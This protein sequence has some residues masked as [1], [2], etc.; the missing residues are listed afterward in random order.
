MDD[1][2]AAFVM[3]AV[4]FVASHGHRF[5]RLY[6]FDAATGAWSHREYRGVD[7]ALSLEAALAAGGCD[8]TALP[9]AERLRIYADCLAQARALA[10][11][12]GEPAT[13]GHDEAAPRFGELQFFN[14]A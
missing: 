1:T 2:E 3:D 10:G 5:L 8:E 6:A 7:A 4:E 11:G 13:S 12:L 14:V 9:A